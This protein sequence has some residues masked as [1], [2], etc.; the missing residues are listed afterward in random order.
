MQGRTAHVR[1]TFSKKGLMKHGMSGRG[2]VCP[3]FAGN[4]GRR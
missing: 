1:T 3:C 4:Y 2:A